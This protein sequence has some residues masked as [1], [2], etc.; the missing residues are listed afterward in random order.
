[1]KEIEA[2]K[3]SE[4]A[5]KLEKQKKKDEAAAKAAAKASEVVVDPKEMFKTA[6]YTEWNEAGI[7]T[8]DKEGKEITKSQLK[9]LTKQ[10]EAQKKK[11]EKWKSSQ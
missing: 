11:Y 5:K 9:K 6:E 3:L 10:F 2:K 4:E 1:M 7:P 8:K